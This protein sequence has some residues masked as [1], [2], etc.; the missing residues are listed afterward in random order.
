LTAIVKEVANGLGGARDLDTHIAFMRELSGK[1]LPDA[2]YY[3][4]IRALSDALC[5]ERAGIQRNI[6]S[7]LK[8]IDRRE[9]KSQME[10]AFKSIPSADRHDNIKLK[11]LARKKIE[12]RLDE[13]L[14]AVPGRFSWKQT[15][16][17]HAL[18]IKTKHLRYALESFNP[19]YDSGLDT[20]ID[21]AHSVQDHLGDFHNYDVW[22][23]FT[24][25]FARRHA[26]DEK[27]ICGIRYVE[28]EC[29]RRRD[30][31]LRSFIR[32][33]DELLHKR[34]WEKLRDLL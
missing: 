27:L 11:H 19:V 26:H 24:R 6:S 32:L 14:K 7:L 1:S 16:E 31:A 30:D 33:W 28:E 4:G 17:L 23:Q 3:P 25:K 15:S 34:K 2:D 18:R 12:K 10:E 8:E 21:A 20:Y 13:F 9:I 5:L 22:L 29:D